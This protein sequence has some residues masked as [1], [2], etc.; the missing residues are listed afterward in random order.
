VH[1]PESSAKNSVRLLLKGAICSLDRTSLTYLGLPG[2]RALDLATFGGLVTRAIC[3]ER[4]KDYDDMRR[5]VSRYP[6]KPKF[7]KKNVWEYLRD[8]YPNEEWVADVAFL[9]FCGGGISSENPFSLEVA[10]LRAYFTK[11]ANASAVPY[12][13]AWTYMPR[14]KGSATYKDSMHNLGMS[15]AEIE[16]ANSLPPLA[17]RSYWVRVVLRQISRELGFKIRVYHHALY[18]SSMNTLVLLFGKGEQVHELRLD[19]PEIILDAPIYEYV[20]GSS[21]PRVRQLF[22]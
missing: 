7:K 9:D 19:S 15:T 20:D 12:V 11:Q 13:F 21:L 8:D 14:D 17:L 3:V 6:L 22:D 1:F 16:Q 4:D 5:S 10:G 18:R 2:K